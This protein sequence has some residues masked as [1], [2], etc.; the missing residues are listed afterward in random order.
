[1]S[2]DFSL[3]LTGGAAIIH[4][5][6]LLAVGSILHSLEFLSLHRALGTQGLWQSGDLAEEV[7]RGPLSRR[8]V[9]LGF[10]PLFFQFAQALRIVAAVLWIVEPGP[11]SIMA[12]LTIHVYTLIRFRGTFNG[13]SDSMM[14]YLLVLVAISQL[15]SHSE[16]SE[17]VI[18]WSITAILVVSYGRAGLAKI[19]QANWRCGQS[20]NVF[21]GSSKY[22]GIAAI[23]SLR[24]S[25]AF[26]RIASWGIILFEVSFP[27]ALLSPSIAFLFVC[28][29]VLFHLGNAAVF[30]LNRFL[31]AWISAYPAL[32][33]CAF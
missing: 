31:F 20:L 11:F 3:Q 4:V 22:Q 24:R 15:G 21:L 6:T 23:D 5:G 27:T 8:L 13:G 30:G 2:D 32:L 28:A 9:T 18:A 1:M 26:L 16:F 17:R 19:K 33:F 7:C 14:L 25:Q 10:S 29:G 12:L